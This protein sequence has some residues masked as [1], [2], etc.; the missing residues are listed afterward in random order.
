[1]CV[2]EREIY[3]N[4][5]KSTSNFKTSLCTYTRYFEID[6]Q[7]QSAMLLL[8]LLYSI[9]GPFSMLLLLMMM[10]HPSKAHVYFMALTRSTRSLRVGGEIA[11]RLLERQ[12]CLL[13]W[14]GMCRSQ[15]SRCR[16]HDQQQQQQQQGEQ[17]QQQHCRL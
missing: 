7:L 16:A 13:L 2:K 1:M 14:P 3:S 12:S 17:Q 9:L 4:N 10:I 5:N 11:N 8:L 6:F 15:R